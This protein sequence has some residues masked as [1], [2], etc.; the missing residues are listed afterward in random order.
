MGC[1]AN[2]NGYFG[3]VNKNKLCLDNVIHGWKKFKEFAET[4]YLE[5][6]I[7]SINP[8]GLRG[9]FHDVYTESYLNK[10]PEIAETKPE[11]LE[12]F[13]LAI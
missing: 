5:T 1:D 7:I 11:I 2:L 4:W 8:V 3:G 6:E 9:L 13:T 12:T 10:H